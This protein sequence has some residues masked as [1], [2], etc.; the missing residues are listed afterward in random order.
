MPQD[1]PRPSLDRSPVVRRRTYELVAERLAGAIADGRLAPREPIPTERELTATFAVG[2]SSVREALRLLQSLGLL[3]SGHRG[4]LVVADSGGPLGRA[5]SLMVSLDSL[6]LGELFEV[7]R[8]LEVAAAGGAATRRSAADLARMGE[9]VV[10]MRASLGDPERYDRADLQFHL[11]IAKASSN[12]FSARLMEGLREAMAEAFTVAFKL[13]GNARR[14]LREHQAI[15][16][17]VTARDDRGARAAMEAHLDRVAAELR[18][19]KGQDLWWAAS[20][21][22]RAGLPAPGT[23]LAV[24][25]GARR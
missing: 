1:A 12:R 11:A 17:S 5:I 18:R 23:G 3:S 7:L 14:S 8:A 24:P 2:R 16:E 10:E 20:P 9:C 6:P 13:P 22:R 21:G 15:A 19:S 25:A 4:E